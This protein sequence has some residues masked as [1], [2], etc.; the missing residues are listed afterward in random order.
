MEKQLR[1][2]Q[3][4]YMYQRVGALDCALDVPPGATDRWLQRKARLSK[5]GMSDRM[6]TPYVLATI[7]NRD[8]SP[9]GIRFL[10]TTQP[11]ERVSD[12]VL[13]P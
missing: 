9:S 12:S 13:V 5:L 10:R 3:P 7:S 6:I 4:T 2:D 1:R 8:V 11:R